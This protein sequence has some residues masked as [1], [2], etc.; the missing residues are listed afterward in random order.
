MEENNCD[1]SQKQEVVSEVGLDFPSWFTILE[2]SETF[3]RLVSLVRES[4]NLSSVFF[5]KNLTDF[6]T[7]AQFYHRL[8]ELHVLEWEA[9]EDI[10]TYFSSLDKFRSFESGSKETQQT[11]NTLLTLALLSRLEH[12]DCSLL[13]LPKTLRFA[14]SII[15]HHNR[16][17]MLFRAATLFINNY[18]RAYSAGG[19]GHAFYIHVL[20]CVTH[21]ARK[22]S[23]LYRD[24]SEEEA[25][26]H[27][28]VID[29]EKECL[30]AL[31]HLLTLTMKVSLFITQD[32]HRQTM[33]IVCPLL[34]CT[35]PDILLQAGFLLSH[36][37]ESSALDISIQVTA[38][39]EY[40]S[41]TALLDLLQHERAD[42]R[43]RAIRIAGNLLVA[44]DEF[45]RK[46]LQS[47]LLNHFPAFL[48]GATSDQCANVMWLLSNIAAS[49]KF[50]M[51]QIINH[52]EFWGIVTWA[53][54][55]RDAKVQRQAFWV[56]DS[57][58]YTIKN[59]QDHTKELA[60]FTKLNFFEILVSKLSEGSETAN[61][62]KE[63]ASSILT[64]GLKILELELMY[65]EH[66][67]ELIT[68]NIE[69]YR[70]TVDI[71]YE[72]AK[73]TE[74]ISKESRE[75]CMTLKAVCD[76]TKGQAVENLVK[77]A[78]ET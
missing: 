4:E 27:C 5:K 42:V 41:I 72:L 28:D 34:H 2:K 14:R 53:M 32:L 63:M 25:G 13:M 1:S 17:T 74:E 29:M 58:F 66:D 18:S 15:K 35:D 30:V 8:E 78:H 43:D 44:P 64:D 9:T 37:T 69:T 33:Q 6:Q 75:L 16:D 47:S 39:M 23:L 40:G 45:T 55:S 11:T 62:V 77:T 56:L 48:I 52:F 71:I 65:E 12:D 49:D 31:L 59:N 50:D 51:V 20:R 54:T 22:T 68:K 70:S 46:A 19:V 21:F 61:D 60:N 7:P 26:S 38:F 57:L 24:F 3:T 67:D 73:D 76:S 10:E 36:A